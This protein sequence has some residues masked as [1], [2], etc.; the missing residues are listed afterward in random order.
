MIIILVFSI[1][2]TAS[3]LPDSFEFPFRPM[4]GCHPFAAH[5][6]DQCGI[7]CDDGWIGVCVKDRLTHS[8]W[9]CFQ[10]FPDGT[11]QETE[12]ENDHCPLS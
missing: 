12:V 3:A 6:N 10:E 9:S 5:K 1:S 7:F 11:F 2:A 8:T 4:K